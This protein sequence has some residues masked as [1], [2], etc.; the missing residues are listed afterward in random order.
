MSLR[1]FYKG[2]R[3]LVTGHTGFKGSWLSIWLHEMGA[4]V[5][6]VALDPQT[7]KDNFVLS[8][9]G[10]KIKADIRA[11]IR[12][13]AEM[14]RI[15][16]TYQPQIVFHLAAQPLVRLSYDEP[17]DTWQTNVMGTINVMEA[18]RHCESAKVAVMPGAFHPPMSVSSNLLAGTILL[19]VYIFSSMVGTSG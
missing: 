18:F 4:E 14:Q 1:D 6:G 8:G 5:I 9:I 11:D 16:D 12:D 3:V 15:V 10:S 17:V 2:K 19:T 13:A 7:E